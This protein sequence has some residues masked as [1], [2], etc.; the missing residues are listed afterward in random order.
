MGTQ[1]SDK[2]FFTPL[3]SR[4]LEVLSEITGSKLSSEKSLSQK[5]K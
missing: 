5:G 3:F 4:S 2:D 1:I